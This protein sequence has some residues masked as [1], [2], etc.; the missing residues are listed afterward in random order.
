MNDLSWL[1][2]YGLLSS[3]CLAGCLTEHFAIIR[4]WLYVAEEEFHDVHVAQGNGFGYVYVL[5]KIALTVLIG[6]LLFVR[7][8]NM[9]L[10]YLW[11]GA[12]LLAV[13]WLSSFVLQFPIQR[14]IRQHKTSALA[15]RLYR[16]DTIRVVTMAIH[17]IGVWVLILQAIHPA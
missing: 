11:A 9:P 15:M 3:Y 7:P 16:T 4:G 17:N 6:A 10:G 5:P 12:G 2:L 14:K 8:A 13:S 1:F